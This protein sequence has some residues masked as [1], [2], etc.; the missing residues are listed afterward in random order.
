MT[1]SRIGTL[2]VAVAALG[3]LA[4]CGEDGPDAAAKKDPAGTL[5]EPRT[6]EIAMVDIGFEPS[7]VTVQA[8]ET[9]RFVFENGGALRHEAVFGDEEVQLEHEAEMAA[10]MDMTRDEA[11]DDGHGDEAEMSEGM[12]MADDDGHDDDDGHG[13]AIPSLS[14]APGESGDL[15]VT[16]DEP[17]T[18]TLSFGCHE[19]GHWDA[20]MRLD[21]TVSA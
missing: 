13:G 14:L 2:V 20:G 4:A 9:I 16:F 7:S 18:S 5:E 15:T 3:L 8:G 19:S 1:M 21:L 12:D 11:D 6:I 10:G 17:G